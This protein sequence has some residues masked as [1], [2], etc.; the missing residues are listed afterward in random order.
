MLTTN[1]QPDQSIIQTT[2]Q[3]QIR[4]IIIIVGKIHIIIT[5]MKVTARHQ[6]TMYEP[7]QEK[8]QNNTMK[9]L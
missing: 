2:Q 7:D 9:R 3:S 4:R 8:N 6:L 5:L 1:S